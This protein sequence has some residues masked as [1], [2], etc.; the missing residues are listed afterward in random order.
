MIGEV[1]EHVGADHARRDLEAEPGRPDETEVEV[2][3]LPLGRGE[4]DGLLAQTGRRRLFPD[5]QEWKNADG[6]QQSQDDEACGNIGQDRGGD[7][8]AACGAHGGGDADEGRHLALLLVGH[9]VGENSVQRR[10]QKIEGELEG[11]DARQQ[12]GWR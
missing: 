2:P 12:A 4:R 6:H 9:Q 11:H 10:E 3:A 5:E 8:N 1:E 7:Q